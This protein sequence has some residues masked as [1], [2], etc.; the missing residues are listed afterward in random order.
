MEPT[1]Q[2]VAARSPADVP[3]GE[4]ISRATEQMSQLVREELQL[5]RAEMVQKGKR[6]GIGGGLFGGAGLLAVLGLQALVVTAIAALAL[7]V[8]VWASA[9]IVAAAL[10]VIA[11]VLAVAGKR[12]IARAVP[13][14]PEQAVAGLKADVET[15]KE[16]AK[17]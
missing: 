6:F 4:L 8:P 14:A 15:I 9:L 17:R 13:P 2:T 16:N 11:A 7:A 12:E 3:V 5:A 10:L 1:E